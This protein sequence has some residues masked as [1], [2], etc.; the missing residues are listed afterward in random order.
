MA[1][2]AACFAQGLAA[3][4]Q[5]WGLHHNAWRTLALLQLTQTQ[6]A[7]PQAGP[8]MRPV[9]RCACGQPMAI[10][11]RRMRSSSADSSCTTPQTVQTARG[12]HTHP[13]PSESLAM[14]R[15]RQARWGT[16]SSKI[17]AA[18]ASRHRTH[19]LQSLKPSAARSLRHLTARRPLILRINLQRP[20][21]PH[22]F[23]PRACPTNGSGRGFARP[24]LI[25]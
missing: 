23:T 18:I 19:R 14:L 20:N 11:R 7:V 6:P 4:P 21:I 2:V 12:C 9:W 16:D 13:T 25:R 22:T 5:L 15:I 3:S 17:S 1:A 24:I 10:L 8:P